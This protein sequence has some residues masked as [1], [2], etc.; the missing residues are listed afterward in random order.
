MTAKKIGTAKKRKPITTRQGLLKALV[1]WLG[2]EWDLAVDEVD[3]LSS[4][5]L[6]RAPF[7]MT[8]FVLHA[9]LTKPV[10][11]FAVVTGRN[12]LD[13]IAKIERGELREKIAAEFARVK[14]TWQQ[15]GEPDLID[16][17]DE[18]AERRGIG[19]KRLALPHH[20]EVI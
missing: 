9:A 4:T 2:H 10:R 16:D 12:L 19:V 11:I 7:R 3:S 17:E 14:Q 5:M 15:P 6:G 18:S 1:A 13:L 20:A 8:Y